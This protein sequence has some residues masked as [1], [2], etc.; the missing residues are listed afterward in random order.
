M[1]P[2][3][4]L[5]FLFLT[6]G[7]AAAQPLTSE[8]IDSLMRRVDQTWI[9]PNPDLKPTEPSLF[10]SENASTYYVGMA[11]WNGNGY[12]FV[13]DHT[14]SLL[15]YLIKV[16]NDVRVLEGPDADPNYLGTKIIWDASRDAVIWLDGLTLKSSMSYWR[17]M[18][19]TECGSNIL[20]PTLSFHPGEVKPDIYD[21]FLPGLVIFPFDESIKPKRSDV[22]WSTIDGEG[23]KG[24]GYDLNRDDILD[25]F[26]DEEYLDDIT[27]YIRLY[28]NIDGKW[29]VVW[30]MMDETCI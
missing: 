10:N 7:Q 1:R 22:E 3:I 4:L 25:V 23:L 14:F 19:V 2:Q 15:K 6:F 28:L 18:E 27:S 5:V 21:R 12:P 29:S 24:V 30:V 17:L 20:F 8:H 11:Q 16:D 26:I 13:W 9:R